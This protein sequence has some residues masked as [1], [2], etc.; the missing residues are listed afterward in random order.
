MNSILL[1]IILVAFITFIAK[2]NFI[3]RY[4]I[5]IVNLYPFVFIVSYKNK[6]IPWGIYYYNIDDHKVIITSLAY[7]VFDLFLLLIP[8]KEINIK[9][10]NRMSFDS[11]ENFLHYKHMA[12]L[13]NIISLALFLVYL[14]SYLTNISLLI[15]VSEMPMFKRRLLVKNI[16][17][18]HFI[19]IFLDVVFVYMLYALPDI[20]KIKLIIPLMFVI[21]IKSAGNLYVGNRREVVLL[22]I[23]LLPYFIEQMKRLSWKSKVVIILFSIIL[24]FIMLILP[25]IRMGYSFE[26]SKFIEIAFGWS[27]FNAPFQTLAVEMDLR[28]KLVYFDSYI[29]SIYK[30]LETI[31]KI[32]FNVEY[33]M[34][35][36]AIRIAPMYNNQVVGW[37]YTPFTE[38]YISFGF[39]GLFFLFPLIFCVV[40]YRLLNRKDLNNEQIGFYMLALYQF[41]RGDLANFVSIIAIYYLARQIIRIISMINEKIYKKKK[42]RSVI[43]LQY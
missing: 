40:L 6:W 21:L 33:T 19:S 14:Y 25:Y 27:D 5:I 24:L 10:S 31:F 28:D 12:L 32:K 37:T 39:V 1:A 20:N 16:D 29:K 18:I 26:L 35:S 9:P 42:L 30:L 34:E 7:L 17:D 36:F 2:K 3:I 4:L 13:V 22:L 43:K 15:G 8:F 11:R 41:F 23:Y 38:A